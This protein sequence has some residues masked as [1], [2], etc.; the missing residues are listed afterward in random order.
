MN[1][2]KFFTSDLH[3]GHKSVI[4]DLTSWYHNDPKGKEENTRKFKSVEEMDQT[5]INNINIMVGQHDEL[6]F[7]GDFA[8]SKY[9]AE[10]IIKYREQI[11]CKNIHFILGNHDELIRWNK[12]VYMPDSKYADA[13]GHVYLQTLFTSVNDSTQIKV[14]FHLPH[15]KITEKT[16]GRVRIYLNHYA[17][18]VWPS[19]HHGAWHL[20]GHSHSALDRK[21]PQFSEVQELMKGIP[22]E[23]HEQIANMLKLANPYW[24]EEIKWGRSMDVGI[25][26]AYRLFGEYRPFSFQ[27]LYEMLSIQPMG[28]HH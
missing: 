18:R 21:S 26:N 24:G 16:E 12:S 13:N 23:Y 7:L 17:N 3:L 28:K 11:I 19:S 14:N 20:Y 25:D 27:E 22:T 15:Q 1:I 5:I 6:Y 9:N 10:A 2:K 4:H 8:M